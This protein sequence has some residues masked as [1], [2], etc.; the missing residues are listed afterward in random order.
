MFWLGAIAL[1][2]APAFAAVTVKPVPFDPK[3]LAVPHTAILG[4]NLILAA[5]VD[6]GGSADSFTYSWNFGDG[7]A[8][9]APA[10]VTSTNALNLSAT[11]IYSSGTADVTT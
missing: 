5:T 10:A 1:A 8:P 9:T 6:L 4:V 7:T 2:C 3:N 11:H